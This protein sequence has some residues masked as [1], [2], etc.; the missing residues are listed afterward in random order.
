MEGTAY[1]GFLALLLVS[2]VLY[3]G[4]RSIRLTIASL[5]TLI[6]GLAGTAAFAAVA[7]GHL[8]LISI[9]FAVLY[10]G[11]GIDYAVHVILGYRE[12]LESGDPHAEALRVAAQRVGSSIFLSAVTT[13][14]CFF[15]FIPTQFTGVSELGIISGTGMLI[16]LFVTMTVLPAMLTVLGP[17]IAKE[18]AANS[19][20]HATLGHFGQ[21][22]GTNLQQHRNAVAGSSVVLV[23]L[24]LLLAPRVRFE[25]RP[26]DL[27]DPSSESVTTYHDLVESGN[28]APLAVSV[29]AP[30]DAAAQRLADIIEQLSVVREAVTLRDFVPDDQDEKFV[31]ISEIDSLLAPLSSLSIEAS[32]AAAWPN[33]TVSEALSALARLEQVLNDVYWAADAQSAGTVKQLRVLLRRWQRNAGDWPPESRDRLARWVETDLLGALPGRM[34]ALRLALRPRQVTVDSLPAELVEWW[35]SHDGVHRVQAISRDPLLSSERVSRFVD[36]VRTVASD[37]TGIPVSDL[38]STRVALAAFRTA[39]VY[40]L[41]ATTL[42]LYFLFGDLRSVGLVVAPLLLA[43][44]LTVA[45]AAIADIPFNFANLITLPLLLG[46]GVDNGI[47]MVHRSHAIHGIPS[48]PVAT[49]TG[50]AVLFA[51]LTTIVSFCSLAFSDHRGIAS[52]GQLLT[53]G[54]LSVLLCTLV[55]LPALVAFGDQRLLPR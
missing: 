43:A 23:G 48:G 18:T 20:G 25:H 33:H 12:A 52:M 44:L 28:T 39:F 31:L 14:A 35:V 17:G 2:I 54:M 27:T 49:S 22:A 34:A 51:S 7:V 32:G 55:V 46:V 9:A 8:N 50:R 37:A 53:I 42:L 15:A 5:A 10:V 26:I 47:H 36:A 45:T 30:T 21:W 40:A 6:A 1:A 38:E 19:T 29:L 24:G 16:S 13:A 11:L 4:L 41:I 3:C